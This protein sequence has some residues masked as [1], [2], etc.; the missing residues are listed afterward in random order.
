[1]LPKAVCVCVC[2]YTHTFVNNVKLNSEYKIIKYRKKKY[3]SY[4]L[5]DINL[6]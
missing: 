3:E 5:T 2:A 6:V 1:M 4:D